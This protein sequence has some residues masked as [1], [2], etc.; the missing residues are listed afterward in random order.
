M[1]FIDYT[2]Y[3]YCRS[4]GLR[5]PKEKDRLFCPSCGRRLH[6]KARTSTKQADIERIRKEKASP[7][8]ARMN[9]KRDVR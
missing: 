2:I 5:I 1:T 8:Y 4:E 3:D 6:K 7:L 9:I